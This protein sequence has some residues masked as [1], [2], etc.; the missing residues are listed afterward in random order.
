MNS[1]EKDKYLTY[2]RSL[3]ANDPQLWRKIQLVYDDFEECYNFV[4]TFLAND[5]GTIQYDK[6]TV[7]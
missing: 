4:K 6:K 1:V 7:I 2:Y 5:D 3:E